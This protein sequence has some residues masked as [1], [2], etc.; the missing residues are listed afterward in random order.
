[1]ADKRTEPPRK[2]RRTEARQGSRTNTLLVP[3]S[4]EQIGEQQQNVTQDTMH[5]QIQSCVSAAVWT[6]RHQSLQL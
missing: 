1:M 5:Q 3:I 4:A 6:L 2:S